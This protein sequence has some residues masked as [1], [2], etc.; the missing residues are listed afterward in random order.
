MRLNTVPVDQP[1]QPISGFI[2]TNDARQCDAS[3]KSRC[4]HRN[5]RRTTETIFFF[6]DANDDT[7]LFGIQLRRIADQISI[8]N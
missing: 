7:W 2:A 5:G 4:D 1:T 6:V 3:T 8:E